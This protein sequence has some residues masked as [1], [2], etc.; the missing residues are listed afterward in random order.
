MSDGK[1][2]LEKAR[3]LDRVQSAKLAEKE[4]VLRSLIAEKKS[5]K[6]DFENMD[7]EIAKVIFSLFFRKP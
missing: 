6:E 1:S 5:S 7:E 3:Q 4:Q 2:E